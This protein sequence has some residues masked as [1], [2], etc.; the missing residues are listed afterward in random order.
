MARQIRC[1][2]RRGQGPGRER[3]AGFHP[4]RPAQHRVA[5][6]YSSLDTRQ[7]GLFGAGW[8]VGYEVAI[9]IDADENLT[10]IDEQGR[11]LE[12][13]YIPLSGGA[14]SPGEGLAVRRSAEGRY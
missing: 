13:G 9:E 10:Y 4:A 6:F 5:A 1:T 7:D 12:V 2:V 11:R 3:R 8:S 14:F